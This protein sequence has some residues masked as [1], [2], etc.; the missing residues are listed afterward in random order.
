[1]KEQTKKYNYA[2]GRRKT[3]S[4]VVKLYPSGKWNLNI[5]KDG[6]SIPLKEYFWWNTYLAEDAMYPLYVLGQ[7][8]MKKY[9]AD[10]VVRWGGI[11]GQAESIR[12]WLTRA[13][14]ELNSEFRLTLKP[15]G[16]LKRDPRK[17]ERMKPGLKKA[18]KSPQWSKR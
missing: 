16:L 8:F 13:L 2:I 18:R 17:K 15:F 3:S 14:V 5:I 1:M 10:I 11:R 12:L 9:D 7:D 6:K 4:A